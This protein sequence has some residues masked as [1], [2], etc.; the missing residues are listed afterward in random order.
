MTEALSKA[1]IYAALVA[2][3]SVNLIILSMSA[4]CLFPLEEHFK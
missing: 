2:K 3:N 1:I 4:D